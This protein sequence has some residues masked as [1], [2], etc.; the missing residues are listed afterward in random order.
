[1][2]AEECRKISN[3]YWK[4]AEEEVK[5]YEQITHTPYHTPI[6]ISSQL[7]A[8]INARIETAC[9]FGKTIVECDL[10]E[11]T[12]FQGWQIRDML[13]YLRWYYK[14]DGFNFTMNNCTVT[15]DWRI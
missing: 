9:I 12:D 4:L 3:T 13:P 10:Y 8:I 5:M 15:I 1:M 2:N 14:K 7:T 11:C 6:N